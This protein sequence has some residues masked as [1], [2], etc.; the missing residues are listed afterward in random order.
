MLDKVKAL[1]EEVKQFETESHE[2]L[3]KFRIKFIT[4]TK[5][6]HFI[7]SVIR[8]FTESRPPIPIDINLKGMAAT[9]RPPRS[10]DPQLKRNTARSLDSLSCAQLCCRGNKYF[11]KIAEGIT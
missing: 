7:F 10:I 11:W 9:H 6:M 1:I 3:E 4:A 2:E 5:A 8:F